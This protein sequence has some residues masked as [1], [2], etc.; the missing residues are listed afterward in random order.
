MNHYCVLTLNNTPSPLIVDHYGV[1]HLINYERVNE[2][3]DTNTIPPTK[4]LV[5]LEWWPL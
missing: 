1:G 2:C 5:T 3:S 4:Y